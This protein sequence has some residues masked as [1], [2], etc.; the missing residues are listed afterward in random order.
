[1]SENLAPNALHIGSEQDPF[2]LETSNANASPDQNKTPKPS[3]LCLR[4]LPQTGLW[5]PHHVWQ[6]AEIQCLGKKQEVLVK[7]RCP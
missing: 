4:V 2:L 1:M 5:G 6:D 7:H 3:T